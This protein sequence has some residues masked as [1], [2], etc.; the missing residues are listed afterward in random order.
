MS[1]ESEPADG[2]LA[3]TYRDRVGHGANDP[4][5]AYSD[6]AETVAEADIQEPSKDLLLNFVSKDWVY[7]NF[8]P[9]EV[10]EYKFRLETRKLLY[11]ALHPAEDCLVTG[12]WRAHINDDPDDTLEPLT[13]RQQVIVDGL[14]QG[15][16]ARMTR[17]REGFQQEMFK[18]Q[19]HE[20]RTQ[21]AEDKSAGGLRDRVFGGG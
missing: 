16:Y 18:T 9:E 6:W 21:S 5:A 20:E 15:I 7:A 11:E 14:F 10:I 13:Q 3:A 4:D 12:E 19:I 17:G 8:N 2:D 1:A